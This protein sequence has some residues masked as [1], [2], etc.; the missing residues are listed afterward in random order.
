MKDIEFED[1]ITYIADMGSENHLS[2]FLPEE[3]HEEFMILQREFLQAIG[4]FKETVKKWGDESYK[5]AQKLEDIVLL[6]K[7]GVK[8]PALFLQ[9][10]E[11]T[12]GTKNKKV[13]E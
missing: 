12:T 9:Q 1:L 8:S 5:Q 3:R 6:L 11:E 2:I 7:Q 4:R 10:V 13:C